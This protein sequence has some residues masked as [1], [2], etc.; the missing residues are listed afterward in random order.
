MHCLPI[1]ALTGLPLTIYLTDQLQGRGRRYLYSKTH[2]HSHTDFAIVQGVNFRSFTVKQAKSLGITG[3]VQNASDGSVCLGRI[4]FTYLDSANFQT[5]VT[6]EAQGDSSSLDKF[7]QHL[8]RG[9]SAATVT[10]LDVDD[11]K[12]KE[13]ESDFTQ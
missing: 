13:G 8:N 9:P 6:G 11:I 3:H 12:T 7:K 2:D 1:D 5:Q 4:A 10:K